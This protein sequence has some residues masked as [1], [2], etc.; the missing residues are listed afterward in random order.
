MLEM[1]RQ[2]FTDEVVNELSENPYTLNVNNN[3]LSL[4]LKAK[5]KILEMR[6][7]GM[8]PRQIMR[9]LGYNPDVL[10]KRRVKDIVRHVESEANSPYGIH[11]GYIRTAKK[12]LSK[13]EID[14]LDNSRA[15]YAMLKNEV[16]YLRE[17]VEFLKKSR[18]RSLPG[19]EA[20]SH[21]QSVGCI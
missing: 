16:I 19:S 12:R 11:E 15:S 10:G 1:V 9:E 2:V 14:Q 5:E 20:N 17:E 6:E 4:T 18:S 21:G 8:S 7:G 13:D 3:R